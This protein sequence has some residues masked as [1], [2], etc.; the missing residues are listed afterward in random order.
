MMLPLP[1]KCVR[2]LDEASIAS[3]TELR[4]N[5]WRDVP[6]LMV[7]ALQL[8]RRL[9]SHDGAVALSLAADPLRRTFWT[10]SLWRDDG[11]LRNYVRG[12]DHAHV[13]RRYRGTL[14]DSR[15]AR[16]ETLGP[17][18]PAWPESLGRLDEEGGA[19]RQARDKSS[20][21]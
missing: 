11:V 7:D 17:T 4:L 16:W 5:R 18:L 14:Q 6:R 15:S 10:L 21:S 19:P 12:G 9:G 13:M 8:R 20:P 2:P 3:I 1:W